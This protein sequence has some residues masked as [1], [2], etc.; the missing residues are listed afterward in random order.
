MLAGLVVLLLVACT[1]GT[2][3]TASPSP[4]PSSAPT[5]RPLTT[6]VQ[7]ALEPGTYVTAS[8]FLSRLSFS[9]PPGWFANVGGPYAVFLDPD[10]SAVSDDHGLVKFLIFDRVFADPC[11][12][13]QGLLS[14]PPGGSVDDL[15]DALASLPSLVATTPTDVTV[16]GYHGKQLT[17]TA[18][19]SIS[20]C[21]FW[22][23]PLG[24]STPM[25]PGQLDRVWILD[26]RGQ[27]LVI[28]AP[29]V[30][31]ESAADKATVQAILDSIAPAG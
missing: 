22:Q 26:V 25:V 30:P 21:S 20:I 8:P 7:G 5:P 27:R 15:A 13:D 10:M 19:T 11:H 16:A 23:L 12:P 9:L 24:A 31:S 3:P 6:G 2:A 17:L 4:T 14:P 18:P 29:E 28:D 1:A